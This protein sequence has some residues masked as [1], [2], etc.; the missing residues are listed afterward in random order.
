MFL[1]QEISQGLCSHESILFHDTSLSL[2]DLK[3]KKL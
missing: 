1:L 2:K 3:K